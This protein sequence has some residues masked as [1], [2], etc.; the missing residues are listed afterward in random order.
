MKQ[1]TDYQAEADTLATLLDPL[2]DAALNTRTQ[3]KDWTVSDVIGHLYMFD[4]GAMISLHDP[5]KVGAFFTGIKSAL[6]GAQTFVEVQN[7]WL[8]GLT[9]RKLFDTWRAHS[10]TLAD[11]FAQADPKQRVKWAGPDMSARS[12]ITARQMETWA[13]GQEVFDALGQIRQE[14]DRI[15]NICHMGAATFGWS[16][17]NR[18]RPV[19]EAPPALH[20]TAPSGIVWHWNEETE[21]DRITGSAVDFARVVT[22]VRNIADTSLKIRG[23][24]ATDWMTIAQ[25]YAGNP[26]DPP[27]PG[28][29]HRVKARA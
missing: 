22:Q 13:H 3:F 2:D 16:Y 21:T 15:E 20:L 9:G 14:T 7:Q 8:D 28:T 11:A 23:E 18:Q 27:A 6:S 26:T 17:I 4:I 10:I 12:S 5:D 29:R 19:P 25:C 1:A 24:T